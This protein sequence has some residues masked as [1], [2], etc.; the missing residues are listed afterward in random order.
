[1]DWVASKTLSFQKC[2]WLLR[3]NFWCRGSQDAGGFWGH[4]KVGF[5]QQYELKHFI[6]IGPLAVFFLTNQIYNTYLNT[7]LEDF[8]GAY[9]LSTAPSTFHPLRSAFVT[10]KKGPPTHP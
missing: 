7:T 9:F 3:S 8:I 4:E 6:R 1:M 5:W 2:Q 10:T